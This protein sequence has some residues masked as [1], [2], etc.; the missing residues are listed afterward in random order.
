MKMPVTSAWFD[1]WDPRLLVDHADRLPNARPY[2]RNRP[3]A[4]RP[5][6]QVLGRVERSP[7][8]SESNLVGHETFAVS[9]ERGWG[10]RE[11]H[12]HACWNRRSAVAPT[13]LTRGN[14]KVVEVDWQNGDPAR[15][16]LIL[17]SE[18]RGLLTSRFR[19]DV[20]WHQVESVGLRAPSIPHGDPGYDRVPSEV[21]TGIPDGLHLKR[22]SLPCRYQGS[23]R[24]LNSGEFFSGRL[25]D[26]VGQFCEAPYLEP[27]ARGSFDNYPAL[28]ELFAG[29]SA[30]GRRCDE[31]FQLSER[32][33]FFRR[34]GSLV[35]SCL[36][37]GL[38]EPSERGLAGLRHRIDTA[39]KDV[40]AL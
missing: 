4:S 19:A 25:P 34:A 12:Q 9:Y 29:L 26:Q 32:G 5:A 22:S 20:S 16:S 15:Q 27:L 40:V 35:A 3:L 10:C 14:P 2:L 1:Q 18:Q 38:G 30:P 6:I 23:E 39:Q 13:G 31:V 37:H 24:M 17:E 7:E 36:P 28:E 33:V 21:P 8:V 11:L